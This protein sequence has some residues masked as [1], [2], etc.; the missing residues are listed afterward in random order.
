MVVRKENPLIPK[1]LQAVQP[2][3]ENSVFLVD[4]IEFGTRYNQVHVRLISPE[5]KLIIDQQIRHFLG[6]SIYLHIRSIQRTFKLKYLIPAIHLNIQLK[7]DSSIQGLKYPF[8]PDDE[9]KDIHEIDFDIQCSGFLPE[10]NRLCMEI[11]NEL[12]EISWYFNE[13]NRDKTITLYEKQKG[14]KIA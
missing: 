3:T 4:T 9:D 14:N 7:P 1:I 10:V 2:L 13:A 8:G 11:K 5:M 12:P 6:I